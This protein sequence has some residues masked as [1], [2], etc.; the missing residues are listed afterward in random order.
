MYIAHIEVSVATT[1][2]DPRG[3][4]QNFRSI[5]S[6]VFV[7]TGVRTAVNTSFE[8]ELHWLFMTAKQETVRRHFV[9]PDMKPKQCKQESAAFNEEPSI[10]IFCMYIKFV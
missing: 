5:S 9:W 4:D 6:K 1:I 10:I 8:I 3:L 7:F 2:L